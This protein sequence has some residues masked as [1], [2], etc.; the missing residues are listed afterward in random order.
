[1]IAFLF[2]FTGVSQLNEKSVALTFILSF[3]N[4]LINLTDSSYTTESSM[5]CTYAKVQIQ[6]EY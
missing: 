1:M 3:E 5:C 6:L 4:F 2:H